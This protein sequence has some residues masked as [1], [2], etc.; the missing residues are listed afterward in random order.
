M[1]LW[2]PIDGKTE[3]SSDMHLNFRL[4]FHPKYLTPVPT[5]HDHAKTKKAKKEKAKKKEEEKAR[6]E[7]EKLEKQEHKSI[8]KHPMDT[9]PH[10]TVKK[11]DGANLTRENTMDERPSL[12]NG[13]VYIVSSHGQEVDRTELITCDHEESYTYGSPLEEDGSSDDDEGEPVS[14]L[15]ISG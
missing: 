6:K 11:L 10:Y 5:A 14:P 7:L 12:E 2:A 13:A 3:N 15:H 8:L 4:S 9:K 1:I